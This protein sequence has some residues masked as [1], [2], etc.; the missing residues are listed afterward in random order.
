MSRVDDV[1]IHGTDGLVARADGAVIR[2]YDAGAPTGAAPLASLCL[3]HDDVSSDAI[4]EFPFDIVEASQL[5]EAAPERRNSGGWGLPSF[6]TP[7]PT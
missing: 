7:P 3:A 1:V 4:S 6:A 2:V 5:A